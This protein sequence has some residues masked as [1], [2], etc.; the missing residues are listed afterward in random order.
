MPIRKNGDHHTHHMHGAQFHSY[1]APSRG[2]RQLCAW[3]TELAPGTAGA[4]HTVSHEEVFLVLHGSPTIT[5]DDQQA[6][7][8][9][10]DVVFVPESATVKLDNPG[11]SPASVWVTTSVGLTA[12]TAGG[13]TITPPWAC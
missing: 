8:C 13:E 10:G 1:V 9:A 2:S 11:D 12:V 3:R 5:L 4:P 6:R 7:L